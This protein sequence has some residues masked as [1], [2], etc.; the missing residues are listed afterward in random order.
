MALA[1]KHETSKIDETKLK[2]EEKIFLSLIKKPMK[3]GYD[4]T[5][6]TVYRL[7]FAHG[8]VKTVFFLVESPEAATLLHDALGLENKE[9][10]ELQEGFRD[11]RYQFEENQSSIVAA[12]QDE[13]LVD[14]YQEGFG[15]GQV[16]IINYKG[17]FKKPESTTIP[18]MMMLLLRREI[19]R[20]PTVEF[21]H[22]QL[23]SHYPEVFSYSIESF[24]VFCNRI[25]LR[26]RNYIS[27]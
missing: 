25:N 10:E 16:A 26:G 22:Q 19:N 9:I 27:K 23:T 8:A 6:S 1:E 5:M 21:I 4:K 2:W 20:A 15:K 7:G 13:T 3:E 11:A 17:M 14:Q 18:Y 12:T 24:K